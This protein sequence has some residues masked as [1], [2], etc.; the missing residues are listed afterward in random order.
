[1]GRTDSTYFDALGQ[2]RSDEKIVMRG[3][4][5][6]PDAGM[7]KL[8]QERL[9]GDVRMLPGLPE[10]DTFGDLER[11]ADESKGRADAARAK[12]DEVLNALLNSSGVSME[13]GIFNRQIYD[14]QMA[15][16]SGD[17]TELDILRD[18]ITNN[19]K[20][21]RQQDSDELA[22]LAS[23]AEME[24]VKERRKAFAKKMALSQLERFHHSSQKG[25]RSLH[26][27][28]QEK[29]AGLFEIQKYIADIKK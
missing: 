21:M 17:R 27:T 15:I 9:E 12:K 11:F 22:R 3:G 14:R 2:R 23:E 1:M 6:G 7:Q 29:L 16:R 8:R 10:I 24:Q 26:Q 4:F 18:M 28:S 5:V 20:L 25:V 13:E 19:Q